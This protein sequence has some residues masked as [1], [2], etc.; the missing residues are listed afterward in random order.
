MLRHLSIKDFVIV[1]RIELDVLPGFTVLTGETGAG[2]SILIDALA[3]ALGERGDASQIR[4]GCERAEINVIFDA[5]HLSELLHWLNDNDLQGDSDSCLMRRIIDTNGR[6]R[7]YINGH[8]VTLQQLRAAGEY[9]VA[10]HSQHAHQSLL[11]KDVQRELLDAFADSSEL[12]RTVRRA[13]QHWQDCYQ[14]RIAMQQRAAESH[15]RREQ[16]E[17]Q[18]QELATLNFTLEEWQTI[19]TDHTRLSHV[20]TLL[21][22]AGTSIDTLSESEFAV[23]TQINAVKSQLQDLLEFDQ[24]LRPITDLLDSA[25]IQLQEGIYE[26][27]HYRQS[28]DLDPQLLQE[29][30]LRMSE[31]HATARKFRVT[32]EELP[33]LLE[34]II[35]Q[36]ESMGSD[37]DISQ[38]QTL[39]AAALTDYLQQAKTLSR[40]RK[41]A[42][43]DLS[44]QVSAAM[45]TMAMIGGEF[46]VTLIP[47][48][49]GNASGLEQI[50]FQVSAHQ[51]LPLRP[52]VKVASGGELSRISLAIQVIT[53]KVDAVPTLIFD[54][55]DVGI[56]GQVAEIV[57]H[58]LKRLGKDRQVL[59][60]THLPQVAATGDQHWRVVK[61]AGKKAENA[62][63]VSK[64]MLLDSQERIE[65]IARM[66]GGVNI[67]ETTRQHAAEML[68]S[69]V[70]D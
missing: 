24:Q 63:V 54:E 58:L 45:Q 31:I 52:L 3:L 20:A 1:D 14:N 64:I 67:T 37:S 51:G 10:I 11:Q 18:L 60:I 5:S 42:S 28:L 25:E 29:I 66:L 17:W 36:L 33:Q 41:K 9:L 39:E 13:Y 19:Q 55:V 30:E 7:S 8:A 49:T 27:K 53:S 15:G 32:P 35:H 2:K 12:A 50:E 57:G 23:L 44:L 59:C 68:Q 21:G 62:Q 70:D 69:I 61:S 56:G 43:K 48:E 38:L 40:A 65:E 46:S 16:L 6:S 22:A 34:T 26:L 4:L 47:L